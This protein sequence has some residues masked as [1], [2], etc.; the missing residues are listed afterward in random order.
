[1]NN[2]W[3]FRSTVATSLLLVCFRGATIARDFTFEDRATAQ[4]AIE[5]AEQLS[6]NCVSNAIKL[7]PAVGGSVYASDMGS[8]NNLFDNNPN[9]TASTWWQGPGSSYVIY[10]MGA[11]N[12]TVLTIYSITA[13]PP[14]STW[15]LRSPSF[16]TFLPIDITIYRPMFLRAAE[17]MV[18][19]SQN[20]LS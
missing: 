17:E 8:P 18:I 13:L 20:M 9:T 19:V 10:D 6:P 12:A 4:K 11:G 16:W 5:Q 7:M 3:G 1:M 15:I 2:R 14:Q